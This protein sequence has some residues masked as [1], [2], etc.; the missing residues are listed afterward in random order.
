MPVTPAD[1]LKMGECY[2]RTGCKQMAMLVYVRVWEEGCNKGVSVCRGSSLFLTYLM[3]NVVS[4]LHFKRLIIY[5]QVGS[6][7]RDIFV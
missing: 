6:L 3:Q 1:T 7:L 4:L 5:I 2:W